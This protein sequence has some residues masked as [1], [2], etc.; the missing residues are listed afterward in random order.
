MALQIGLAR[1]LLVAG[2]AEEQVQTD[3]EYVRIFDKK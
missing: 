3:I 1:S 2:A